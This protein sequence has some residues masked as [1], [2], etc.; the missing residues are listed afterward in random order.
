MKKLLM[1]L[2]LVLLLCF[3]FGCELRKE[4]AEK[5]AVNVEADVDALRD[6][7][8]GNYA[9]ADSGDLESYLGFW[10]EDVIWMPPNAPIMQGKSTIMEYVQPFFEQLTIHHEISIEEIKVAEDLAFTRLNSVEKYTPKTGEGEPVELNVKAIFLLQRMPDGTWLCTH[11][12]W[13]SNDPLPT[14]EGN[15]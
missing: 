8:N 1:I 5:P 12:I 14:L 3:T 9:A 4:R 2:P 13:N 7:V 11:S 6:W 15:Q 10:A